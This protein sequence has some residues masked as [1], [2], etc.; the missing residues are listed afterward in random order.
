MI[1]LR[2][3]DKDDQKANKMYP[4]IEKLMVEIEQRDRLVESIEE[5]TKQKRQELQLLVKDY[6]GEIK[7]TVDK[8]METCQT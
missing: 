3:A 5:I 4:I 2:Y 7:K 8:R 1:T 6:N